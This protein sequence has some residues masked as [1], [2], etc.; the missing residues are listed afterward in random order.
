MKPVAWMAAA[1]VTS[2]L[3]A[4]AV[5][6]DEYAVDVLAGLLAPLAATM[7]SLALTERTVRRNPERV[8]ALMVKAFAAKFVFFGV[9]VAAALRLW[10]LGPVPFVASFTSYFVALYLAE[11]LVLRRLFTPA[12]QEPDR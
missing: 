2:A 8:T 5:V 11:A 9:Y 7:T 3:A 4:I 12:H 6:G 10:S 1:S